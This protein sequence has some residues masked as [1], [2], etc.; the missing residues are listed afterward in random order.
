MLVPVAWLVSLRGLLVGGGGTQRV[1]WLGLL[2][3]LL[4]PEATGRRL[5]VG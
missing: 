3:T 2:S 4:G 1:G 5:L